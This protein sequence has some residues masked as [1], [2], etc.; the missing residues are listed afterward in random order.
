MDLERE[1]RFHEAV[2][3]AVRVADEVILDASDG[4]VEETNY[5]TAK[6][7]E[8]FATKTCIATM[9]EVLRKEFMDDKERRDRKTT[10]T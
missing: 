3:R 4:S 7:S 2:E 1:R 8:M 5:L 6:I 10:R 9:S